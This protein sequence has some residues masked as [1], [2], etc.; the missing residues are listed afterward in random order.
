MRNSL[1]NIRW[2]MISSVVKSNCINW[3]SVWLV[4]T[5]NLLWKKRRAQSVPETRSRLETSRCWKPTNLQ[6]I[7]AVEAEKKVETDR[8]TDGQTQNN[9]TQKNEHVEGAIV[10]H[11]V[12]KP[13]FSTFGK[14]RVCKQIH[15]QNPQIPPKSCY[16]RHWS[17]LQLCQVKIRNA[18]SLTFKQLY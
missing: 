12:A 16:L 2:K 5:F 18:Q 17:I 8:Q 6:Q 9:S 10:I 15:T 1:W 3:N 11:S 13:N 4:V 14:L 7:M